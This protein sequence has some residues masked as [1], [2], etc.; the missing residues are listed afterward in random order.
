MT[1][2]CASPCCHNAW[3]LM[4]QVVVPNAYASVSSSA[5]AFDVRRRSSR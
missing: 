5:F 1:R 4:T 3:L 2:T